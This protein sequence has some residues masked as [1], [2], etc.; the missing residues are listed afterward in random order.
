MTRDEYNYLKLKLRKL[1]DF[2]L[3]SYK[4]NQMMRRLDGLISR[5]GLPGVISFVKLIEQDPEECARLKDF[6]TI[7][8]SEFFRDRQHFDVLQNIVL[9]D[10]LRQRPLLKIWSAGCSNGA[11]AYSVALILEKLSP[12]RN[13]KILAT[14]ID[15]GI[16][17][18]AQE[19]GPYRHHEV[20]N[21][22]AQML[23]ECFNEVDGNF[24]IRDSFRNK[25]IFKKHD[26]VRD[27]YESDFDL[28]ICRNV[29][30]YFSEEAKKR[31]KLKFHQSLREGGILF[32]GAT[33]TMLD[34]EEIGFQ[35]IHLC[36]FKRVTGIRDLK[37]LGRHS[38]ISMV[39]WRR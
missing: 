38:G 6:L 35:K 9:P 30:I 13:H 29:V 34:A 14:D 2:D 16:L 18:R 33:E 10:L 28:I 19:G 7:N 20:R 21:V 4:C 25:V 27:E 23:K 5:K 32:I 24:W 22:P 31:L 1:I 26:L 36:F 39:E 3:D 17:R 11:E 15:E 37:N 12:H 8:V